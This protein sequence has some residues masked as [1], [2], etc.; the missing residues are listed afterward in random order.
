[1]SPILDNIKLQMYTDYLIWN[2]INNLLLQYIY[3]NNKYG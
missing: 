1:M 3:T 2:Y